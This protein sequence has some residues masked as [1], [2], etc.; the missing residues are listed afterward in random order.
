[1][2]SPS[3]SSA[4][5]TRTTSRPAPVPR[6]RTPYFLGGEQ[7]HRSL[8]G[9]R[10]LRG[11]HGRRQG[12]HHQDGQ[13]LLRDGL[14]GHLP[15]HGPVK[16]GPR[17]AAGLRPGAAG[18]RS[19]QDQEVRAQPGARPGQERQ[20]GPRHRP[21]PPPVPRQVH[22]SSSTATT[23]R[24]TRPC[25]ATTGVA[26][27]D[28]RPRCWRRTTPRRHWRLDRRCW[29]VRSRAPAAGPNYKKIPDIDVRQAIAFAYPYEDVWS[30][31]ASCPGTSNG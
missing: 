9:R 6:T 24:P 15:G 1:M 18:H 7:V 26:D 20:L 13:A 30:A 17:S 4:P 19:V 31:A 2:R 12:H 27:H 22:A 14:L 16:L 5:W 21:G 29:S 8:H 11:H 28:R 3:A 25:S 10:G 23:R